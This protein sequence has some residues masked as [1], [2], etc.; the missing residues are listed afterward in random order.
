MKRRKRV[1]YRGGIEIT[2]REILASIAIVA[3]MLLIGLVLSNKISDLL[4][5]RNAAY[6]KAVK[7]TDAEMFR[8]GM[9][10]DVGNAFVYG[11]Y[12]AV[13]PVTYPEIGGGYMYIEKIKERYTMHTRTVTRDK[14]TYTETYYTWDRVGSEEKH[15]TQVSFLG[16]VFDSVKIQTPYT[17]HITTMRESHNIRYVYN[18]TEA[19]HIGTIFTRLGDNTINDKSP[20]YERDIEATIDYLESGGQLWLF[21]IT[22][23][24]LIGACMYGFVRMEND[25]LED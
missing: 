5:D 23:F 15:C 6:N 16:V 9:R 1:F 14:K 17:G 3:V 11:D 19:N 22:W 8:Y 20:F 21:W 4:L 10:T 7:I 12:I 25:W 2:K 24:I 13:D 18:G